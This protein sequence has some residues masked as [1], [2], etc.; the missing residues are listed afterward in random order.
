MDTARQVSALMHEVHQAD[1]VLI[2][3]HLNPDGDALGSALAVSHLLGQFG[4]RNE[5]VCHHEP[6]KNLRFLPGISRVRQVPKAEHHDLG[7]I[8]DL[9]STERLGSVGAFFQTCRRLV[10]IDHHVP[11]EAPGDVRIVDTEACATAAILARLMREGGTDVTP[12][13]ATCLLTGIVTDTGSFRYRNTNAEALALAAFL[14]ERG[15]DLPRIT[16]EIFQRKSLSGTRLLA[17]LVEH[18]KLDMNQ[19]MAWGLLYQEDY[20]VTGS[21]DEDTEGFVN[22]LLFIDTVQIAAVLRQPKPGAVRVSLR[23]RGELDVARV[24]RVFGG[25]G[26]RNAAGCTIDETMEEAERRLTAEMR[27]CL[28]SSLL[29]SR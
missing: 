24:A 12:E 28:E 23:S 3:T 17:Q 13:I 16:E 10:V 9:D 15:G 18:M 14:L 11:H 21:C 4:R 6:P 1:S 22:E 5:V 20:E 26:H 27:A 19:R 7:I 2:G 8:V 25:G 29:T